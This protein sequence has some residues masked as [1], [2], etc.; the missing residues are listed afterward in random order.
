MKKNLK[1]VISTGLLLLGLT[2]VVPLGA[3]AQLEKQPVDNTGAAQVAAPNE[4]SIKSEVLHEL[5]M[6]PYYTVFDDLSFQVEG[7][8]VILTGQVA[9]PTLKSDAEAVVKQVSGVQQVVNQIEVLP[10][11]YFDNRI[12]WAEYR[13]IYWQAGMEKYAMQPNPP[14][15]IIV[16][17]G[18]VTLT[19]VVA[20]EMD[21]NLA[22]IR[23]NG[24]S[25]VFSVTN[26][27]R[28]EK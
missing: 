20:N 17:N 3:W 22:G 7:N 6:L 10:V 2:A 16:K 25:G 8:Q 1:R 4:S 18:N 14:I 24:V 19:G 9:W 11:S 13:A 12:R 5:R 21:K 15:H 27:L 28:V 26:N 23:A